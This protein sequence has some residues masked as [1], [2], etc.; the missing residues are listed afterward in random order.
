MARARPS[1]GR[2]RGVAELTD[3]SAGLWPPG[4]PRDDLPLTFLSVGFVLQV[5]GGRIIKFV[6]NINFPLPQSK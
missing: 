4:S 3:R 6:L 1:A 2:G 5:I